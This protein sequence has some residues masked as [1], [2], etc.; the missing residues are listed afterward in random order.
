MQCRNLATLTLRREK[1]KLQAVS[2][3]KEAFNEITSH[4]EHDSHLSCR[5]MEKIALALQDQLYGPGKGD[6]VSRSS[7]T[8]D[9]T[10]STEEAPPRK[11][12]RPSE[13][14]NLRSPKSHHRSASF[15]FNNKVQR[16]FAELFDI[17]EALDQEAFKVI[18]SDCI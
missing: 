18:P 12:G 6:L 4:L 13:T 14:V 2:I 9:D 11:R 16:L 3:L 17:D 8:S 15:L 10:N 7:S 1:L 5:Y